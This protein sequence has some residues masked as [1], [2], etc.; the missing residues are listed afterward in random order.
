MQVL[1][2]AAYSAF[3]AQAK[4]VN[5]L[6]LTYV[7]WPNL[8][9]LRQQHGSVYW[10]ADAESALSSLDSSKP[11]YAQLVP[12]A[13]SLPKAPIWQ[14]SST[15]RECRELEEAVGGAQ[16]LAEVSGSRAYERFTG[17]QIKKVLFPPQ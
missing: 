16:A 5:I 6:V 7:F 4:S 9:F 14:D 12:K 13:F 3:P 10:S 8:S 17:T 2:L 15:T 1:P 11:L